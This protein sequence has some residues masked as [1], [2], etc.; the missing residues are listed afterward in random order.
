MLTIWQLYVV[1]FVNGVPDG[2]LRRR[3]TSRTCRRSSSATSSSRATPSSRSAGLRPQILGQPVAGGLDRAPDRTDRGPARLRQLRRPRRAS[4]P[5]LA[6]PQARADRRASTADDRPRPQP[7]RRACAARSPRGCATSSAIR[8]LRSIA[9]CTGDRRT[10]SRTSRLRSFSCISPTGPRADAGERR[11][12]RRPIGAVGLLVAARSSRAGRRAVRRRADDRRGRRVHL[13]PGR[14]ADRRW[15]PA[16]RRSRSSR[17]PFLERRFASVIYNINQVSLRQAITP[18]RIQGRMNATMRFLVWGTIPI[19]SDH[20][21]L[22]ER[23]ARAARDDLGRRHRRPVDSVPVPALVGP[24]APDRCRERPP[25][26]PP[27]APRTCSP[28]RQVRRAGVSPRASGSRT[29]RSRAT[30]IARS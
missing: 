7:G 3:R 19:G 4:V 13:R 26:S 23:P 9:A 14:A 2:L 11:R 27:R 30:S 15:P 8:Y 17:R 25:T 22:L 18:E 12:D 29:P 24:H 1:G 6:H 20:R 5:D 28:A 21:R 10:C 16:S